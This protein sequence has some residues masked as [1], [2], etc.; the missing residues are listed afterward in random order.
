MDEKQ[1]ILIVAENSVFFP[2]TIA[3]QMAQYGYETKIT[4]LNMAKLF[5][6]DGSYEAVLLYM[7]NEVLG[8]TQE[9]LYLKDKM[10]EDNIPFFYIGDDL[11]G[12]MEF[13]PR[14]LIIDVFKRP[15]NVKETSSK[16]VDYIKIN[17]RHVK[18]KILVVDDSGTMLRSVKEWLQEKYQVILANSGAMA[19]KYL[20]INRP[21]LVLLDYEMPIIDGCQVLEMMRAESEFSD[22]PVIFLTSKNDKASI[23]KVMALKPEGYILKNTPPDQ[24]KKEIDDFFVKWAYKKCQ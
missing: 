14:H 21:D 4:E 1:E 19:I 5:E 3:A 12:L 9:L 6:M 7:E 16:I 20:S 18:K 13:I 23:M 22:I 10:V 17:G 2:S 15:I 24:I 8:Y 11:E